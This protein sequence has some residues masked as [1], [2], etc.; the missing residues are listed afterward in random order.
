MAENEMPKSGSW[1]IP[2]EKLRE[3]EASEI[4]AGVNVPSGIGFIT[5]II[6]AILFGL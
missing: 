1:E 3:I 4:P 6:S 2:E 5:S